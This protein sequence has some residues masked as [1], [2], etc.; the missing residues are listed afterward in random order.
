VGYFE[1]ESLEPEAGEAAEP[2]GHQRFGAVGVTSLWIIR[3]SPRQKEIL[4]SGAARHPAA[5]RPSL[6]L[7]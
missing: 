6:Y 1:E 2:C 7:Q 5:C 3:E 4:R